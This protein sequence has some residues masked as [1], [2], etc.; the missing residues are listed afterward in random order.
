MT[1]SVSVWLCPLSVLAHGAQKAEGLCDGHAC[2]QGGGR[3]TC[4]YPF[5]NRETEAQRLKDM[6]MVTPVTSGNLS[7]RTLK[8]SKKAFLPFKILFLIRRHNCVER[9][10]FQ[11]ENTVMGIVLLED[12]GALGASDPLSM[13]VSLSSLLPSPFSRWA[14]ER[15]EGKART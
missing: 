2:A 6:S 3:K 7:Y 14:L 9:S 5:T 1:P 11:L 13:D 10:V 15:G 12:S 4:L 8:F